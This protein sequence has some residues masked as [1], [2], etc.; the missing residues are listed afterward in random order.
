MKKILCL[1]SVVFIQ[2]II[3]SSVFAVDGI[4]TAPPEYKEL[5][6]EEIH[7]FMIWKYESEYVVEYHQDRTKSNNNTPE[8]AVISFLSSMVNKDYDWFLDN[9]DES[10][11]KQIVAEDKEKNLSPEFWFDLWENA[12]SENKQ[13]LTHRIQIPGYMLIGYKEVS[14]ENPK[15]VRESAYC[16]KFENNKWLISNEIPGNPVYNHWNDEDLR[17]TVS[18]R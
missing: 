10:S 18:G 16:L 12:Y 4:K 9:W 5:V 17:V 2:L 14:I 3:A 11:R 7:P 6:I 1:L 15:E 8:D 13:I